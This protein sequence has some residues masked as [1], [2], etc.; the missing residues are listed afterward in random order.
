[1]GDRSVEPG[2]V[3]GLGVRVLGLGVL[4]GLLG[5]GRSRD[6]PRHGDTHLPV[7]AEISVCKTSQP[8]SCTSWGGC[9]RI[10]V[11]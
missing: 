5:K 7:M 8:C 11:F 6:L 10:I 9:V 4:A 1:M 2:V 3:V